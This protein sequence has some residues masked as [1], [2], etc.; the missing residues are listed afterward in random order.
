MAVGHG[1]SFRGLVIA[2]ESQ[3]AFV[4][5]ESMA[6]RRCAA[7]L[8]LVLADPAKGVVQCPHGEGLYV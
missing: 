4:S 3:H 2:A 6:E 5:K 7:S 8:F 1:V